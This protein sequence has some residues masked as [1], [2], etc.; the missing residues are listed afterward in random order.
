MRGGVSD[1]HPI[2]GLFQSLVSR[3]FQGHLGLSDPELSRYIG[4][5][6]VDFIHRDHIYRIKNAE[7]RRL[8]E[9]AEMLLEGD[10]SLNA[11]SFEREREVHKQIGDFTLFWTGVYPEMVRHLRAAS[12]RD[13]LLDY[14]EQGRKSYQIASTFQYGAYADE[15]PILRQLSDQFET[16]MVGLHLVRREMDQYGTPEMRSVRRLLGA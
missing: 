14:V 10:V 8:E 15:A 1:D 12:R 4:D 16:C 3:A 9:V 5:V 2:R 6:L 13:H 11:T 7:G